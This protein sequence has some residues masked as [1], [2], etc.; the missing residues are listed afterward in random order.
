VSANMASTS[1]FA[2]GRSSRSPLLDYTRRTQAEA[3]ESRIA[4]RIEE[5]LDGEFVG[6][7]VWIRPSREDIL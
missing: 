1:S 6:R 7:R 2:K 5:L 3:M 4:T